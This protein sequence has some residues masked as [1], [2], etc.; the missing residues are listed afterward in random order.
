MRVHV[1]RMTASMR[2][3]LKA[4]LLVQGSDTGENLA[5]QQL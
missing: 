1:R 5:L 2:H 3:S 4:L